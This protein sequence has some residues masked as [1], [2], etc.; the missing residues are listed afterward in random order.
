MSEGKLQLWGSR[1][2]LELHC[3]FSRGSSPGKLP[4]H[5]GGAVCAQAKPVWNW[6]QSEIKPFP[7]LSFQE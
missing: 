7:L 1:T 6:N 5:L 3:W 4:G 2:H